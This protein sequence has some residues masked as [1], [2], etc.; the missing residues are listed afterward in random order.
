MN[1]ADVKDLAKVRIA[2]LKPGVSAL[3]EESLVAENDNSCAVIYY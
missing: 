3:I 1:Y 2:K